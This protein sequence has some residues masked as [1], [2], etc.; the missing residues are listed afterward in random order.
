MPIVATV[1][2]NDEVHRTRTCNRLIKSHNRSDVAHDD[3]E[4]GDSPL[5]PET[6]VYAQPRSPV[7]CDRRHSIDISVRGNHETWSFG[8]FQSAESIA[9]VKGSLRL[10]K[11][12]V[13]LMRRREPAV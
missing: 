3:I 6:S 1:R 8:Q 12:R 11:G 13:L 10:W 7:E 9:D 5:R 4:R 2:N